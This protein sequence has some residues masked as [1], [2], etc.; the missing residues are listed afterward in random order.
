[1][2]HDPRVTFQRFSKNCYA[3]LSP[4]TFKVFASAAH[5]ATFSS[6]DQSKIMR[7]YFIDFVE[8]CTQCVNQFQNNQQST[9]NNLIS[10]MFVSPSYSERMDDQQTTILP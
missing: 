10:L 6:Y 4:R 7:I 9:T 3:W 1:M 8:D 5:G 2:T